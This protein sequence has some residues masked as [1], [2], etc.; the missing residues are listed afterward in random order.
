MILEIPDL[1]IGFV[2]GVIATIA[3]MFGIYKL[4]RLGDERNHVRLRA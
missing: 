1:A 2:G 3:V 4:A